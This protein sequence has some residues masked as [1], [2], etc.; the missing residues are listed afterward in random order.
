ML[1]EHRK[2]QR[3]FQAPARFR[4]ERV[5]QNIAGYGVGA[6]WDLL[7]ESDRLDMDSWSSIS[8]RDEYPN[9]RL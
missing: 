3:L 5:P 4:T 2:V 6:N 9:T 7:L 1:A 8:P